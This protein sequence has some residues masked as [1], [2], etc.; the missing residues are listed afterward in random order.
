MRADKLN[1]MKKGLMIYNPGSGKG[2]AKKLDEVI[3]KF[4][5]NGILI[6]PYRIDRDNDQLLDVLKNTDFDMVVLAGGDGTVNHGVNMLLKNGIDVPVGLIP[7]G[8]ANDFARCLNIPLNVDT[9][10]DI[11]TKGNTKNVDVGLVNNERYFLST[12]GGGMFV[13]A[14]FDPS[15]T[16]LKK[17]FGSF[18]YYLKGLTEMMNVKSFPLKINADG[19]VYEE[20]AVLFLIVNGR[21]AGGFSNLLKAADM[22]DGIMDILIVKKCMHID[23]TRMFLKVFNNEA[24]TDENVYSISAKK[25]SISIPPEMLI[26]LDGERGI[27]ENSTVEFLKEKLK[28]FVD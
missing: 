10:V 22:S 5:E 27:S 15:I 6:Q 23:L 25:C 18:A 9:C 26:T 24:E 20:D 8:T 4:Q 16:E 2:L 3:H 21:H 11:I 12:F 13:G 17:K 14:S 7:S 28:V 19:K 1:M